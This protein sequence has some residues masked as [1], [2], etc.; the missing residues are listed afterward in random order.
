MDFSSAKAKSWISSSLASSRSESVLSSVRNSPATAL[1]RSEGNAEL[2]SRVA[3]SSKLDS[4]SVSTN[5]SAVGDPSAEMSVS[6][7]V[8]LSPSR[9]VSAAGAG[10]LAD[11]KYTLAVLAAQVTTV[12]GQLDGNND[13]TAGGDYTLVGTPANGLF[14]FF[15]DSNGDGA[16][17]GTDF[18]AFRLA[19]QQQPASPM[20]DVD[21]DS[22]VNGADFLQFRLRFFQTI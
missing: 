9:R 8:S 6:V 1:A 4:E 21:G 3:A 17:N 10:S 7:S 14:R 13:G 19:F 16:V 18:L 11:G 2:D 15:G 20:F 12:A 22:Q 5:S